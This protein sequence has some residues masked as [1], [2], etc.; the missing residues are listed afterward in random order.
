[1]F[2]AGSLCWHHILTCLESFQVHGFQTREVSMQYTHTLTHTLS[3]TDTQSHSDSYTLVHTWSHSHSLIQYLHTHTHSHP[4]SDTHITLHNHTLS[5]LHIYT[6]SHT[7]FHT[8]SHFYIHSHTLSH[9]FTLTQNHNT[10]TCLHTFSLTHIDTHTHKHIHRGDQKQESSLSRESEKLLWGQ[11][12][13]RDLGTESM[14]TWG[15]CMDL[16]KVPFALSFGMWGN[17]CGSQSS[18]QL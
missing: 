15:L 13:R 12:D 8:L 16:K 11:K 4:L 18:S 10:Y 14:G 1:M 9:T 7:L 5:Y 3:H 17:H 2:I 6:H